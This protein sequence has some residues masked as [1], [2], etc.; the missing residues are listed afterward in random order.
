MLELSS[1]AI[2]SDEPAPPVTVTDALLAVGI[3]P[4]R[5]S[6]GTLAP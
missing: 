3:E 1:P 5:A 2:A 4:G 6:S